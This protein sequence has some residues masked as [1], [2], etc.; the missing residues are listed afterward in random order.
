MITGR[1]YKWSEALL[2]TC[3]SKKK[4]DTIASIPVITAKRL[5]LHKA[6]T[7]MK[8]KV[9]KS[10]KAKRLNLDLA[11]YPLSLPSASTDD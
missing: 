6:K 9:L 8:P 4:L 10:G 5:G 11:S 3:R 1:D 2:K 7:L